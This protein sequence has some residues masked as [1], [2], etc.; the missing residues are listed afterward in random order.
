[1]KNKLR[2]QLGYFYSCVVIYP[3]SKA[4]SREYLKLWLEMSSIKN[5]LSQY[6]FT[7]PSV[8]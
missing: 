6:I 3:V 8:V 7:G 2:G 4:E 5:T 1:M